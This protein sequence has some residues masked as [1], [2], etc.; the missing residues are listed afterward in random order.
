M[1]W[2]SAKE[3]RKRKCRRGCEETLKVKRRAW[4]PE[5]EGGKEGMEGGVTGGEGRKRKKIRRKKQ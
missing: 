5:S 4:E 3:V 1:I 2:L